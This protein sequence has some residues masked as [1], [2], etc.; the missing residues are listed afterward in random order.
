MDKLP[1]KWK[2]SQGDTFEEVSNNIREAIA[3]PQP[4]QLTQ[5]LIAPDSDGQ[6]SGYKD[7]YIKHPNVGILKS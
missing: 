6:S 2:P 5:A 4:L 1:S 3:V 7:P